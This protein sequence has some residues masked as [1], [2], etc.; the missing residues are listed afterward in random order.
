MAGAGLA[1]NFAHAVLVVVVQS[2]DDS[3]GIRYKHSKRAI[4]THHIVSAYS[5]AANDHIMAIL[6]TG[7]SLVVL[8]DL[9]VV[10]AITANIDHTD[11]ADIAQAVFIF[12]NAVVNNLF[13]NITLV[14]VVRSLI[15]MIAGGFRRPGL[16]V[17]ADL[18]LLQNVAVL[19]TGRCLILDGLVLM[20]GAGLATN[21]AYAVLVLVL[22]SGDDSIVI[23]Y[24]HSKRTISMHHI[25]S[26]YSG[27]ANDHIMAILFTG[28]SQ[29][30]LLDLVIVTAITADIDHAGL[31]D[32]AQ[33]VD[34]FVFVNAIILALAADVTI[35]ILSG[36]LIDTGVHI[37]SATLVA[38][39][40]LIVLAV[41]ALVNSSAAD[42]ALVVIVAGRIFA[43][44]Q[45]AVAADITVVILVLSRI[46]AGSQGTLT[47]LVAEVILSFD[48][49]VRSNTA[50]AAGV[51]VV[52]L[53][54]GRISAGRQNLAA[55]V[56]LVVLVV[57]GVEAGLQSA[58]AAQVAV[59]VLITVN[60]GA[61]RHAHLAVVAEVIIV[62]VFAVAIGLT[63][64]IALMVAVADIIRAIGHL[65]AADVAVV[66]SGF[67]I[68]AIG[69]T[70]H[71][72]GGAVVVI[73]LLITGMV[74]GSVSN[75]NIGP[76][77]DG[78][79]IAHLVAEP[80]PVEPLVGQVADS[81]LNLDGIQ[82]VS[83]QG[84]VQS[85]GSGQGLNSV[86]V[87]IGNSL[88]NH[89]LIVSDHAAQVGPAVD[90]NFGQLA[91]GITIFVAIPAAVIVPALELVL[92]GVVA[93]VV[94]SNIQV[95]SIQGITLEVALHRN[96]LVHVLGVAVAVNV[97]L[98]G[99]GL[100]GAAIALT[101]AVS[102]LM[103][104]SGDDTVTIIIRQAHIGILL[105]SIVVGP[106]IA[107]G[108]AINNLILTSLSAGGSL[109]LL[110]D[111]PVRAIAGSLVGL[112][113]RSAALVALEVAGL[114]LVILGCGNN[115]HV[116]GSKQS[117]RTIRTH[118]KL[119][120]V[121][122]GT[123]DHHILASLT[124]GGSFIGLD[125]LVASAAIL[126]DICSAIFA[127]LI[128]HPVTI[129]I[130]NMHTSCRKHV[131]RFQFPIV[132]SS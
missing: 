127:A 124:T 108:T 41:E 71:I 57:L 12:V 15:E 52:I 55:L 50:L 19:S 72:A 46:S 70:H 93:G 29:I 60:I 119:T 10:A 100:F 39:V 84:A 122:S 42:V 1:T 91:V 33:V 115:C 83:Q 37:A 97:D 103:T 4:R 104:G 132:G 9:V 68:Y 65:V 28:R 128:T 7:R 20:A 63:A 38:L 101:V 56:A 113:H 123:L 58:V 95:S 49:D 26:A 74:A 53:I 2:G 118:H 102:I 90:L 5:G 125:N 75:I 110:N 32:I 44:S 24:K 13:A 3:I 120:K 11:A 80:V 79:V 85:S 106:V 92:T 51:A 129:H 77:V 98:D 23:R 112:A 62:S 116:R 14:V 31:T 78:C 34:I 126:A 121:C 89:S 76:A 82:S 66:I 47:A 35:V 105:G 96:A 43:G 40:I 21:A 81:V 111:R 109:V 17:A 8:L 73:Q 59:M 22:Q 69:D 94:V 18:A 131:R 130:D 54:T 114:I 36:I 25:V 107:T 45:G 88:D 117:E 99:L 6:F 48:V 30:E 61:V 86:Q 67:N 27:A 64:D 16:E 87:A